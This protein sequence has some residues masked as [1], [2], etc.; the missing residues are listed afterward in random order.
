MSILV[1]DCQLL[2]N[3]HLPLARV[4]VCD[5]LTGS[6]LVETLAL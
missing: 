4:D 3:A 2:V 1:I 6:S 5:E